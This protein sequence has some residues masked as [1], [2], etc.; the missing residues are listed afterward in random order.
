MFLPAGFANTRSVGRNSEE[1]YHFSSKYVND[2]VSEP[3]K[4][5]KNCKQYTIEK[6]DILTGRI[7]S[8]DDFTFIEYEG[9]SLK[10][11]RIRFSL[12]ERK[13]IVK[14]YAIDTIS[15]TLEFLNGNEEC[16]INIT[17]G[18]SYFFQ[19]NQASRSFLR[20]KTWLSFDY[21]LSDSIDDISYLGSTP[22]GNL[23][24]GIIHATNDFL[25]LPILLG[26]FVIEETTRTFLEN[27]G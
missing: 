21:H 17:D 11:D 26:L 27:S 9:Q 15:G 6:D 14:N 13:Y 18:S 10:I 16:I 5:G 3:H 1:M 12:T 19:R 8:S 7:L 25:V 20:P 4:I 23:P 22:L 24:K 2:N